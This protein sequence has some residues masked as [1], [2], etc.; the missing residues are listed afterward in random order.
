[1][2]SGSP[3]VA[4]PFSEGCVGL[5]AG[6]FTASLTWPTFLHEPASVSL[7]IL[8]LHYSSLIACIPNK[9]H[10]VHNAPLHP[11]ITTSLEFVLKIGDFLSV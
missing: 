4:A 11:I 9:G 6:A 1:M 2:T 5:L 10:I 3:E 7:L 8:P